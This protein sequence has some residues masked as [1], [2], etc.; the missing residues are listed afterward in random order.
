MYETYLPI[1][2]HERDA[3]IV[4]ANYCVKAVPPKEINE[5]IH[6]VVGAFDAWKASVTD[7]DGMVETTAP[8]GLLSDIGK[9]NKRVPAATVE[10][11]HCAGPHVT[12]EIDLAFELWLEDFSPFT[13]ILDRDGLEKVFAVLGVLNFKTCAPG[14]LVR[15]S[16]LL[17]RSLCAELDSA[18]RLVTDSLKKVEA[19]A[20]FRSGLDLGRQVSAQKKVEKR[21]SLDNQIQQM[22]RDYKTRH[23]HAKTIEVAEYIKSKG[24]K[25]TLSTIQRKIAGT[26][27]EV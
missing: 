25:F 6:G 15:L 17:T 9:P 24:V 8:S 22:A 10:A 27:P 26:K 20:K 7:Q 16:G 21:I 13:E 19:S 12:N 18:K 4:A 14:S 5:V 1:S 11:F 3:L 2:S 23:P